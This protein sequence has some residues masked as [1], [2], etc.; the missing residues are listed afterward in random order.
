MSNKKEKSR[1]NCRIDKELLDN[2][3]KVVPNASEDIREYMQRR[4]NQKTNLQELQKIRLDKIKERDMLNIEIEELEEEIAEAKRL[5]HENN[6]NKQALYNAMETVMKVAD[7]GNVKGITRDKVK[8]I[9]ENNDVDAN[10][11]FRECKKHDIK[12]ITQRMSEVNSIKEHKPVD[13]YKVKSEKQESI[14][15]VNI[16][17]FKANHK[18]YNDDYMRFLADPEI[19]EVIKNSCELKGLNYAETIE[20][21]KIKLSKVNLQ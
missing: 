15:K 5:R 2:Y 21:L 9:A 19:D 1:F 13:S 12:F 16:R 18:K 17:R 11:L 6:L 14:I 4:V 10:D 8:D 7:S 3:K 20:T